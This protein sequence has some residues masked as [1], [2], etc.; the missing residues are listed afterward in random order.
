MLIR[1]LEYNMTKWEMLQEGGQLIQLS[2]KQD[3]PKPTVTAFAIRRI[4]GLKQSH[5]S[6]QGPQ[7]NPPTKDPSFA[8]IP[9]RLCSDIRHVQEDSQ[10]KHEESE[11]AKPGSEGAE[12]EAARSQPP[13]NSSSSE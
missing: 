5:S 6:K 2:G 11:T 10:R 7:M 4:A 13:N 1:N 9:S 3:D 12:A 8:A